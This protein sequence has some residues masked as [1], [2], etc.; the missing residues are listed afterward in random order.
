VKKKKRQIRKFKSEIKDMMILE[1]HI[2]D[3]NALL[4]ETSAQIRDENEQLKEELKI[5]KEIKSRTH[6][7]DKLRQ[8]AILQ[9]GTN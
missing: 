5:L 2:K 6:P 3:E 4:K 7:R 1:R 9:R 8:Q